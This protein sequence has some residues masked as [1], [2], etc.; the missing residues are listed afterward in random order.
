M[1]KVG[2]YFEDMKNELV[3]KVSWPTWTE[4]QGSSIVVMIASVI[5]ALIVLA[6]DSS[7]RVIMENIYKLAN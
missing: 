4:L 2:E 6:M 1:S 3:H 5:I 7:F